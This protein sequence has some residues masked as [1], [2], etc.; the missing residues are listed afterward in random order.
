VSS[1]KFDPLAVTEIVIDTITG[2]SSCGDEA[3]RT[4]LVDDSNQPTIIG[5]YMSLT[6]T[7][8]LVNLPLQSDDNGKT[9]RFTILGALWHNRKGSGG[10]AGVK[11]RCAW[12]QGKC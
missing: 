8:L 6:L 7:R 3:H 12:R 1:K 9:R 4:K 10:T 5:R 2:R 11:P